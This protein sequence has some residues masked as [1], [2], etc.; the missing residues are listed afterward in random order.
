M[1]W[2]VLAAVLVGPMADGVTVDWT[3]GELRATGLAAADL[4]LPGPDVARVAAERHARQQAE[5]RLAVAAKQLPWAEG[6]TVGG[7][8]NDEQIA[9]VLAAGKVAASYGSDGSTSVVVTVPLDGF[10][11]AIAGPAAV[12]GEVVLDARGLDV[13]PTLGVK[14]AGAAPPTTWTKTVPPNVVPAPAESLKDGVFSTKDQLPAPARLV[15]VVK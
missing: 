10:R 9:G 5:A 2:L 7:H 6:G 3:A 12:G 13:E 8:L 1:M 14:L 11:T 4:R 15:V